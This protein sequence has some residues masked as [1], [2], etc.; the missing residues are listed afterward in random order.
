MS[1]FAQVAWIALLYLPKC[2]SFALPVSFLFAISYTLGLFYANNEL[3]AIFGS[4]RKPAQAGDPFLV[5]GVSSV[6]A[7]FFEDDRGHPDLPG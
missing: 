2:I 1:P 4:G 7:F 5:L 3:F 6:G